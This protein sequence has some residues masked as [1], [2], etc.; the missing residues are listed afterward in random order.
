MK[1]LL[2][3]TA[4]PAAALLALAFVGTTVPANARPGEYC[5]T[6]VTSGMRSCSFSTMEECQA[7]SSGRGGGCYRDPFM[8]DTDSAYAYH[9]KQPHSKSERHPAKKPV[10]N[11]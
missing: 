10:G 7:T 6:D 3:M 5:R 1:Q 8:A 2:K 11:Q 4:A 9:P